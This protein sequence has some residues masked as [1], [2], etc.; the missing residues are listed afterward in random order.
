MICTG[1][2]THP[3]DNPSLGPSALILS[4]FGINNPTLIV[5]HFEILR[6]FASTFL[7]S[8]VITYLIVM[9]SA[10]FYARYIEQ[11]FKSSKH[12]GLLCGIIILGCNLFYACVTKGASCSSIPLVLGLNAFSIA[13][14]KKKSDVDES[15]ITDETSFPRPLCF[16]IFFVLFASL[17]LPFNSWVMIAIAIVFGS[18]SAIFVFQKKDTNEEDTTENK[19]HDSLNWARFLPVGVLYIIMFLI[20]MFN[21]S[22][23]IEIYKYPYLTGCD[24]IYSDGVNEFV[25]EYFDGSGGGDRRALEENDEALCAQFCVPHLVSIPF[26]IGAHKYFPSS[27]LNRGLCHRNGFEEHVADTTFTRFT[28]S[29]DVS[30]YTQA[31]QDDE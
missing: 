27:S 15:L 11:A 29:L 8:G 10:Y 22:R 7:C 17:L 21:R 2:L 6:L 18:S 5:Y 23:N 1:G 30:L 14:H 3:L 20:L 31:D 12:F 24:M 16:T 13:S 25:D 4:D 28:Y 26:S 19:P 9:A